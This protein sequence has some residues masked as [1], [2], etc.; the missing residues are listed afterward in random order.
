MP[1]LKYMYKYMK[2]MKKLT[3]KSKSAN[4]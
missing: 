3:I 1:E 2:M 4:F